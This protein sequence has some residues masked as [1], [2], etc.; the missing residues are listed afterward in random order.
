[1]VTGDWD[2]ET[3]LDL[4]VGG[5]GF[6]VGAGGAGGKNGHEDGGNNGPGDR[7]TSALGVTYPLDIYNY[8][9]IAGGGGGGGGSPYYKSGRERGGRRR[10]VRWVFGRSRKRSRRQRREDGS[11]GGG[12]AGYSGLAPDAVHDQYGGPAGPNRANGRAASAGTLT[13]GG[14]GGASNGR[15]SVAG[16]TGGNLGYPGASIDSSGAG[17]DAGHAIII[18][19]TGTATVIEDPGQKVIGGTHAATY[20]PE[21]PFIFV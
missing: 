21:D 20:N 11:P 16:G 14:A 6:I 4:Y 15:G 2:A 1:M 8:G 12:G 19:G 13:G 3:E 17:G 9:Y 5:S 10:R 18:S 7:G